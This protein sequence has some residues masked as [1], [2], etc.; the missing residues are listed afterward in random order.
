MKTKLKAQKSVS[1][2]PPSPI[3]KRLPNK[4]ARDRFHANI[5]SRKPCPERGF[6]FSKMPKSLLK[7]LR[8]LKWESLAKQPSKALRE[9]TWEFYSGIPPKKSAVA[10]PDFSL[11]RGKKVSFSASI[12]ITTLAWIMKETHL[13]RPWNKS[14]KH[15][16]NNICRC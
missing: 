4:V 6:L 2:L 5:H 9:L 14:R 11:V 1:A 3:E 16:W 10:N 8:Q 12:L 7:I 15:R 13:M